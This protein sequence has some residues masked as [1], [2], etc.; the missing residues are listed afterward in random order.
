[1]ATTSNITILHYGDNKIDKWRIPKATSTD[2]FAKGDLLEENASEK[3]KIV[4]AA[5]NEVFLGVSDVGSANGDTEDMVINL[6]C[7]INGTM[8]SGQTATITD[9]AVK[10]SAGANGTNWTFTNDQTKGIAW[11]LEA[12]TA[13]AQ[14]RMMIDVRRID[15]GIFQVMS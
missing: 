2:V 13:A 10:Y 14:G 11:A 4:D 5:N 12:F 1:M 8:A 9:N 7:I 15:V 3:A 6:K